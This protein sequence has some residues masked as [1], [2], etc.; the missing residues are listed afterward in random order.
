MRFP[1]RHGQRRGVAVLTV[2]L[3][4]PIYSNIWVSTAD[5]V[6]LQCVLRSTLGAELAHSWRINRRLES[7]ALVAEGTKPFDADI[8]KPAYSL[9]LDIM[10]VMLILAID[11]TSEE[12]GVGIFRDA[13]CLALIPNQGQANQYSITLFELLEKALA[14]AQLELREIELYAAAN[15][16]GSFTGIRVGLAAAM[17]WG[18]VFN[19]PVRGVSVL[20]AMVR[21]ACPT[22]DWAFPIMD[23]RRGEFFLAS[24][25]RKSS[26][27]PSETHKNYESMDGGWL[28]KPES[29]RAFIQERLAS[30]VA[31]TCLARANDRSASDLQASLPA[32]LNWQR[33]DGVLL[34]SIAEIAR[35]EEQSGQSHPAAK[36]D[37]Y[38]LRRPDAEVNWKE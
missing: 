38:Y 13:E 17:A 9:G 3:R 25:Q 29:L 18:K 31:I 34:S 8:C 5:A 22:S 35:R 16:P 24:F 23:A 12:G 2:S 14:Q 32:S 27:G 26:E 11:T 30:G 21:E 28:F 15:G 1:F 19:R 7:S 10:A 20:E 37:A 36:L 33:V 6:C 4:Q